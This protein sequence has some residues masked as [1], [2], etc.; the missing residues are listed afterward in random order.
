LYGPWFI[1]FLL[2]LV[3]W[4][5]HIWQQQGWGSVT[6]V[7]LSSEVLPAVE[8]VALRM[9]KCGFC[10]FSVTLF[11]TLGGVFV[12]LCSFSVTLGGNSVTV[13]V[14]LV[15]LPVTLRARLADTRHFPLQYWALPVI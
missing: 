8:Q 14:T 4:A 12:T 5:W 11:V 10:S 9:F 7:T 1:K 3:A 15:T 2:L 13:G 6:V